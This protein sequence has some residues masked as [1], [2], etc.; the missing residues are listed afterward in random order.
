MSVR[1]DCRPPPTPTDKP[2]DPQV[3]RHPFRDRGLPVPRRKR[4]R[5][6]NRPRRRLGRRNRPRAPDSGGGPLCMPLCFWATQTA[7]APIDTC[8]GI[9]RL[10]L[11]PYLP[12]HTAA[13]IIQGVYRSHLV[14]EWESQSRLSCAQQDQVILPM[15]K[16]DLSMLVLDQI[17]EIRNPCRNCRNPC[18]HWTR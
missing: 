17:K 5:R 15:P 7:V 4:A 11:K 6:H 3:L 2:F 12:P 14:D 9:G 1:G 10:D 18:G 13:T 16:E 8:A